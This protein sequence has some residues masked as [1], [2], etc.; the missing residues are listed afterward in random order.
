MAP[1]AKAAAGVGAVLGMAL[2]AWAAAPPTPVERLELQSYLGRWYQV[3]ASFT[4]K[5]T[6]ELGGNCVTADYGVLAGRADAISVTNAVDVLGKQVKV[7]GYAVA[8]TTRTGVFEVS[9]GPEADPAHA[10]PFGKPNYLVLAVGPL[11]DGRYDYAVVSD[12][13]MLSL[14]ILT[15]DVDRFRERYESDVLKKVSDLGFTSFLNKPRST[16]QEGC[17]YAPAPAPAA[18][19]VV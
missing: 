10:R 14:Y 13:R 8:D 12:P 15:R 19:L 2:G 9:L 6:M 17:T 18:A 16:S 4:V 1:R 5:Y 7:S 11:V 3:Y